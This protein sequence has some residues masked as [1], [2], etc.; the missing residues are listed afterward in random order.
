MSGQRVTISPDYRLARSQHYPDLHEF[1]D[2][3]YWA[4]RGDRSLLEAW[5]ARCDAVKA[6]IPKPPATTDTKPNDQ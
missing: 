1:A 5:L 6:S 3:V 2:A 4:E